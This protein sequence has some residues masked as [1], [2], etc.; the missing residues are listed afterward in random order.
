M[1]PTGSSECVDYN[2]TE[3][4]RDSRSHR[5]SPVSMRPLV[6]ILLSV[7]FG[8][9]GSAVHPSHL[10]SQA[11]AQTDFVRATATALAHGKRA[12][13]GAAGDLTRCDRFGGRCRARATPDRARQ[14]PRSAG[15]AAAARRSR[16]DGGRGARARAALSDD[17]RAADAEPLLDGSLQTRRVVHGSGGAFSAPGGRRTR[18]TALATPIPSIA[19]PNG[20]AAIRR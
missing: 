3:S 20:P 7:C 2:R 14:L 10:Y 17:G 12:E 16:S 13:A 1:A 9:A 6:V 19:T 11:T 4:M 5:R 8:L 18:S 15:S